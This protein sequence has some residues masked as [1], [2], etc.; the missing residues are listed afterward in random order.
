MHD[1]QM[2]TVKRK[3]KLETNNVEKM[4][5]SSCEKS[6]TFQAKLFC[7][8]NIKVIPQYCI[9]HL[10]CAQFLPHQ[11]MHVQNVR[12]FPQTKL[13]SEINSPFLLNEHGDHQ[14]F[15]QVFAKNSLLKSI[16]EEKKFDSRT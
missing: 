2:H 7:V 15:F 14:C 3:Y 8:W 9:A 6:Q 16:L 11:R 1:T 12:D 10:Y 13:H 4:S 5:V